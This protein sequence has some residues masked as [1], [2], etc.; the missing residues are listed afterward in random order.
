MTHIL[1]LPAP[2]PGLILAGLFMAALCAVEA[3]VF[4]ARYSRRQ[5][6]A[7]PS[8]IHL[9]RT[10]R[11][12]A[13]MLTT[14]V[15]FA[16]TQVGAVAQAIAWLVMFTWF[17]AELY[18]RNA[19]LTE[20][21]RADK[22]EP[23]TTTPS[24]SPRAALWPRVVAAWAYLRSQEP[25]RVQAAWK[26]LLGIPLAVGIAVPEW[27][28]VRVSAGIAAVWVLLAVLQGEATRA[29]VVPRDN[30]EPEQWVDSP[31]VEPVQPLL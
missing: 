17:A 8:G 5:W 4:V 21:L 7:S 29:R 1:L 2:L 27:V 30:T 19:L 10:T 3:W 26:A 12:I 11:L 6:R 31:P 23:M 18:H 13:L 15:V 16:L 9:M 25:A 28:D 20:A 24:K 22:A 14:T